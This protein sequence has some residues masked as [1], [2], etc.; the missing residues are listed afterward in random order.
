MYSPHASSSSASRPHQSAPRHAQAEACAGPSDPP[1]TAPDAPVRGLRHL[2]DRAAWQGAP[3]QPLEPASEPRPVAETRRTPTTLGTR[4]RCRRREGR[5]PCRPTP[6]R[7]RNRRPG[8]TPALPRIRGLGT[9]PSRADRRG[10]GRGRDRDRGRPGR[11]GRLDRP[12]PAHGLCLLCP[13]RRRRRGSGRPGAPTQGVGRREVSV[14]LA[15][16]PPTRRPSHL[17]GTKGKG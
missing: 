2:S 1:A 17:T 3:S 8:P 5:A 7:R 11:L 4:P 6:P 14:F 12:L 13:Y 16:R 9:A 15:P 10:R